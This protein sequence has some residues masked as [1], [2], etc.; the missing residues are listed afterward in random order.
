MNK[1]ISTKN[2]VFLSLVGPAETG[3]SQL[4]YNWLQNGT[5][6]PKFDKIH[7]FYQYSQTLYD[8]MQKE[9]E[10]LEFV[11][12]VHFEFID[13]SNNN[14]TKYLLL[15]DDSCD[16]I[17]NSKDFLDISTAGRHR[18]LSTIYNRDNL[19][20]QIKLVRDV[21][22]Q[23]THI[24]RF[25]SSHG[26]TQVSTVSAQLG[27]GSQ[28]VEWYRDATSVPHGHLLIDFSPRTDDRLHYCTNTGALPSKFYIPDRWNS[29]KFWTMNTQTLS[30]LQV[31][32]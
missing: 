6:E 21:E 1:L 18:G 7:C 17:F 23:N 16:D 15:F 30:T 2:R 13:S 19:F 20:H 3:K 29:Q 28:L 9:V 24:V 31:F 8:V 26:V 27:V 14:G 25:K 22:L 12:G 10:N 32:Q 11:Q 4:I 5:F